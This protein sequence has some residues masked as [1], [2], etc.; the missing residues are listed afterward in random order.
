MK[1]EF[2]NTT[3]PGQPRQLG[4]GLFTRHESGWRC[5]YVFLTFSLPCPIGFV[6]WQRP[7]LSP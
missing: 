3:H 5:R 1:I 7:I 4:L 6:G 2:Y